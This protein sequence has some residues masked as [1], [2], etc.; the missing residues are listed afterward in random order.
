MNRTS[1]TGLRLQV[2]LYLISAYLSVPSCT[3]QHKSWYVV[4]WA[5]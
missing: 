2:L 4:V 3:S 5:K 1:G